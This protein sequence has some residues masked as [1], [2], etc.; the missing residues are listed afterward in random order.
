[1]IAGAILVVLGLSVLHSAQR[2]KTLGGTMI[3]F[4]HHRQLEP[5]DELRAQCLSRRQAVDDY[6]KAR[7]TSVLFAPERFIEYLL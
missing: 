3:A 4:A 6:L 2:H 1:M 5:I 7:V